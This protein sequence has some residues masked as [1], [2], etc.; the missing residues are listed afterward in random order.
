MG[1]LKKKNDKKTKSNNKVNRSKFNKLILGSW[2]TSIFFLAFGIF[3]LVK[4]KLANSLIGYIVGAIVLICGI[5]ALVNYFMT[6]EDIKYINWE[7]IYGIVTIIAGI[8]IIFNP[9]AI[10]SIVTIGLGIWMLINGIMKTN[11]GIFLKKNKEETWSIVLA[12]GV[13]TLICGILLIINPFKGTMVVTQ[14]VGL[15][16]IVYAILDSMHW[17]LVKKRSKD[18]VEFIK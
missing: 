9:L 15:F 3:L 8:A 4:P 11:M 12:I 7:L 10:T 17:F 1:K 16:V 18:I 14:V 6:K 13:M 5:A 2:F